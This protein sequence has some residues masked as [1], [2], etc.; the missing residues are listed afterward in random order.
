[1]NPNDWQ[2]YYHLGFVHFIERKDY[3]A[4][5]RA[6]QRGSEV[7]GAHP[8][9]KVMAAAMAQF[10]GDRET[11]RRLW[12]YILESTED[13]YIRANVLKRLRA[14]EVDDAVPRLEERIRFFREQTGAWPESWNQMILAGFLRGI[15][16]DPLGL[17]YKLMPGGRVEVQKPDDLPFIHQGLPRGREPSLFAAPDNGKEEKK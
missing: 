7:P 10:G 16:L 17:P 11:A 2:L 6:F 1:S 9:M 4:A 14:L 8:W 5:S 3:A 12:L 13:T 15:P